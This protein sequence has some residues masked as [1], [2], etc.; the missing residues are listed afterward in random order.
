LITN[1]S[2]KHLENGSYRTNLL[3]RISALMNYFQFKA[4]EKL[5]CTNPAS[6]D[7]YDHEIISAINPQK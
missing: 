6:Q 7:K 3:R 1:V 2:L 5:L 4:A